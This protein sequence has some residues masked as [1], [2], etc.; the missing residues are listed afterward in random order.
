MGLLD[1]KAV[2]VTGAGRGIGRGHALQFAKVGG[3]AV[4]I[5]D[6]DG[7][8]AEKVVAEIKAAGGKAIANTSNIC[9]Q[10]GAQDLVAASR[11]SWARI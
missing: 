5:N 11:V 8:E 4:V 7:A 9:T 10:K 6:I 2:I 1:G 3:A